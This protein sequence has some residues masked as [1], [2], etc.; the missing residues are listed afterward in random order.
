MLADYLSDRFYLGD[1]LIEQVWMSAGLGVAS[2][3][4]LEKVMS[5]KIMA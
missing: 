4:E 1:F 2:E 3:N 5:N